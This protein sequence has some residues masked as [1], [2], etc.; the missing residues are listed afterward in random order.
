MRALSLTRSLAGSLALITALTPVSAQADITAEDVWQ[1]M[2]DYLAVFGGELS[3]S[4]SRQGDTLHITDGSYA[5]DLPMGV[6]AAVC[7]FEPFA[8]KDISDRTVVFV[9]S[10]TATY[11]CNVTL[12]TGE[13]YGGSVT[14]KA[15]DMSVVA[16][17]APGNVVYDF[18]SERLHVLLRD[19]TLPEGLAALEVSGTFEDYEGTSRVSVGKNVDVDVAYQF[20]N[21]TITSMFH[22]TDVEGIIITAK[23]RAGSSSTISKSAMTF[24]RSGMDLMNM[25]AALR[26]GLSVEVSTQY[27][28][29]F[30][31][32]EASV[33]GGITNNQITGADTYGFD[34]L[35]NAEG[36]DMSGTAQNVFGRFFVTKPAPL[37]LE[38]AADTFDGALKLPLLRDEYPVPAALGVDLQGLAFDGDFWNM[39]DPQGH[40]P[41]TPANLSFDIAGEVVNHVEWLDF[42]NV[43]AALGAL[44]TLPVELNAL[45]LNWFDMDMLG[46]IVAGAGGAK[47]DN[48]DLETFGGLPRPEGAFKF[49]VTGAN[50]LIDTL[51]AAGLM[52][53]EQAMGGRMGLAMT[54]KPVEG[55]EPDTVESEIEITAE[56]HVLVNGNRLK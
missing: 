27:E 40:L 33:D 10:D 26:D 48:S 56:G 31:E 30:T 13:V 19:M 29:Y 52:N 17:G 44:E 49:T 42:L 43:E 16:R 41:S 3:A 1:N 46:L 47:F 2:S 12:A 34:L 23:N 28:G 18:E 6:G 9:Q 51:V 11:A 25:V 53:D 37:T 15:H 7:T 24:P 39:A 14:T 45:K 22:T 50:G 8:L 55:G 35:V 21:G 4:T 54:T 36:F 20:G 5:L 32:Q 38:F